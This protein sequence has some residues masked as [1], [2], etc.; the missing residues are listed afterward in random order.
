MERPLLESSRP[1]QVVEPANDAQREFSKEGHPHVFEHYPA[2][3]ATEKM[4]LDKQLNETDVHALNSVARSA[5]C[6]GERI[7]TVR[8]IGAKD[9][10]AADASGSSDPY[11]LIRLGD[12]TKRTKWLTKNLN[13]I[14]NETFS[15]PITDTLEGYPQL[16][17]FVLDHDTVTNEDL[18][19]TRLLDIND[20]KD[21]STVQQ[22]YT[23]EGTTG[24]Q[25][26]IHLEITLTNPNVPIIK[27]IPSDKITDVD[28]G[29]DEWRNAGF[30]LIKEGQVA[31]VTLAGADGRRLAANCVSEGIFDI[32]LPSGLTLFAVQAARIHRL[33]E[34]TDVEQE[35]VIPWYIMVSKDNYDAVVSYFETSSWFG[36][37]KSEV[38]IFKQEILPCVSESGRGRIVMATRSKMESHPNGNGDLFNAI[39]SL[40]PDMMARGIEYVQVSPINNLLARVG[41]PVQVGFTAEEQMDITMK[42]VDK[43]YASEDIGSVLTVN[44][45]CT[46]MEPFEM[47]DDLR[48][49]TDLQGVPMFSIGNMNSFVLSMVFF[50]KVVAERDSLKYHK[51]PYTINNKNNDIIVFKKYASDAM[52]K[53]MK[54]GILK[55]DRDLEFAP[56]K[57][58]RGSATE[59]PETAVAVLNTLHRLW[60]SNAGGAMPEDDDTV[61]EI[62]PDATYEGEDVEDYLRRSGLMKGGNGPVGSCTGKSCLVM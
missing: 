12:Q 33:K 37:A 61:V 54:Y 42:V 27:P 60:V 21:D 30:R 56:V 59:S 11:C 50:K 5:M 44:G 20:M 4:E 62:P 43:E 28:S 57:N 53:A 58:P 22:W 16:E 48:E 23:I 40:V 39:A 45:K 41:D 7:L 38:T 52:S 34:L 31:I 6:R 55:V 13:P 49:S 51:C 10:P 46:V 32:G 47:Q 26:E 18:L 8:V 1:Q 14:W 15:I 25:G 3:A 29:K 19:G 35:P 17:V 9:L 24:K 36:L 2:L